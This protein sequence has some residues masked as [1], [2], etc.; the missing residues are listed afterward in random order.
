MSKRSACPRMGSSS[1]TMYHFTSGCKTLGL[2]EALLAARLAA[3]VRIVSERLAIAVAPSGDVLCGSAADQM[4]DAAPRTGGLFM[5]H[6]FS[7]DAEYALH[8]KVFRLSWQSQLVRKSS[9]LLYV[10]NHDQR[11]PN[12]RDLANH[13]FLYPQR[14][15]MLIHSRV[16]YVTSNR[17]KLAHAAHRAR[18]HGCALTHSQLTIEQS[19]AATL[20]VAAWG[21]VVARCIPWRR[22]RVYGLAFRGSF[23]L[24]QTRTS[25]P[26]RS[27]AWRSWFQRC[28]QG[29]R[30]SGATPFRPPRSQG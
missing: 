4:L 13:L 3:P 8:A 5:I 14:L 2:S 6:G 28:S 19:L 12:T 7:Q 16:K 26:L 27:H 10:N 30:T 20:R 24:T 9:L 15:R 1:H 11:A 29:A 21:I 23:E 22:P 17:N 25:R 18:P